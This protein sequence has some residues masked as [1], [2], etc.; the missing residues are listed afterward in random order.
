MPLKPES[1]KAFLANS[2]DRRHGSEHGYI[3]G[4][5][6]DACLKARASAARSRYM[7]RKSVRVPPDVLERHEHERNELAQR[8]QAER[9][10]LRRRHEEE[11][12]GGKKLR[13]LHQLAEELGVK[14]L[15]TEKE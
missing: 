3:V 2:D 8:Q 11:I 10:E 6:C 5:R 14:L 15:P 12:A 1:L 9:N 4:C 13:R 7:R